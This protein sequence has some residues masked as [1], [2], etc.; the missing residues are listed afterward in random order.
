MTFRKTGALGA[1]LSADQI[2]EANGQADGTTEFRVGSVYDHGL[3][4][5]SFDLSYSRSL[6]IHLNRPVDAMRKSVG[7]AQ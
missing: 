3:P 7:S 6:L 2:D 5:E 1:D 4:P